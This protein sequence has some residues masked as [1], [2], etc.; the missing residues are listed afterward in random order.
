M[1]T[2][3][4]M[5]SLTSTLTNRLVSHFRVQLSHDIQESTP[6]SYYPLTKV[7]DVIDGFGRSLILPR[8]TRELNWPS[9]KQ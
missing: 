9:R 2:E 6:N 8:R 1:H 5:T 7:T 4:A 3:T